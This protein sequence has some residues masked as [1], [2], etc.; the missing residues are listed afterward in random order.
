[1]KKTDFD[2]G[3][4]SAELEEILRKIQLPETPVDEVL[5][6]YERGT[7]LATDLETYLK[8]AE[9]KLEKLKLKA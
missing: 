2:F 1:M 6:L 4:K 8:T 7:K 9:N 5:S 3:Q